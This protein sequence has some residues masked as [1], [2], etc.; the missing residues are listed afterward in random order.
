MMI[1]NDI[2]KHM[3]YIIIAPITP[4]ISSFL[5]FIFSLLTLKYNELYFNINIIVVR[6]IIPDK[7]NH[8]QILASM[9]I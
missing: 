8:K 6:K 3:I 4:C 5:L 2:R 9:Y 7:E 1:Y